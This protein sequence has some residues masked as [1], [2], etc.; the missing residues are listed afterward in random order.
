M[1]AARAYDAAAIAIRGDVAITNF[2][3][4]TIEGSGSLPP[5][6]SLKSEFPPNL[7]AA[8]RIGAPAAPRLTALRSFC[9][10]HSSRAA[11][12]MPPRPTESSFSLCMARGGPKN[13]EGSHPRRLRLSAPA[14]CADTALRPPLAS[15]SA[16][17]LHTARVVASRAACSF[18]LILLRDPSLC[19]QAH[20]APPGAAAGGIPSDGAR[21]KTKTLRCDPPPLCPQS[22]PR[23]SPPI[24]CFFSRSRGPPN[25]AR[26]PPNFTATDSPPRSHRR[27]TP[28]CFCSFRRAGTQMRMSSR[29][30]RRGRAGGRGRRTTRRGRMTS[31]SFKRWTWT[32]MPRR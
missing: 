29:R 14:A 10:I 16:A 31:T 19:L 21:K 32:R 27:R 30:G 13:R 26:L 20:M 8:T 28:S 25:A 7:A 3:R 12:R 4:D 15:P 2:P 5:L 22:S 11:G 17:A 23:Y 18:Q 6:P 1:Q 9:F 24:L